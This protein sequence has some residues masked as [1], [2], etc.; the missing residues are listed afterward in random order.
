M[1]NRAD[2]VVEAFFEGPPEA[3]ARLVRW[4]EDGPRHATVADVRVSEAQP[5]GHARFAIR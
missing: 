3:V 1:R 2:G 4:C 5:E